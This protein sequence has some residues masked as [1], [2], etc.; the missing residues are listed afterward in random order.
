[1]YFLSRLLPSQGKDV[2]WFQTLQQRIDEKYKFFDTV[3]QNM[4][5]FNKI[6]KTFSDKLENQSKNFDNISHTLEDQYLYD[7]YK[8]IHKKIIDN[9]VAENTFA[10]ENL[11]LLEA[12]IN[13][14]KV[15]LGIYNDLKTIN[16]NLYDQKTELKNNKASYHSSGVD[17][18]KKMKELLSDKTL[19]LN[20]LPVPV[21]NQL[22]YLA[23]NPKKLLKKYK[24]SI[25]NVNDLSDKFNQKQNELFN[26]LP[27]FSN[28]DNE[29]FTVISTNFLN[30]IKKNSELL[31]ATK[32][33]MS[34][35]Q[36]NEK[37][38]DLNNLLKESNDIKLEEQKFE[39]I[40]Y[41]SGLE[42]SKCK[43]KNEFDFFTKMVEITNQ[44]MEEPIFPNYNYEIDLKN[45]YQGKLI[46]KI[47]E[48]KEIDEKSEK[49]FLDSL[50]DPMN[51][52][53]MYIV[54]SQLRTNNTFQRPKPLIELLGK[55]F[56][57]MINMAN[58]SNIYD[59]VRN[60]IILSQTY[61]YED[62]SK[63]KRYL[64]EQIKSNKILNNS[65]FWRNF[66]DSMIIGE[67][68]RFKNNHS[69]PDYNI[70]KK[71]EIPPKIIEKLDEIVF[72]QLISFI[73]NLVDFEMDKKLI[74]RIADEFIK[75]YDYL[76]DSNKD[77]IY[78]IIA[79][80]KDDIEKLRKEYDPSQESE[81]IEIKDETKVENKI[82]EEKKKEE[83]KEE[84]KE[85]IKEEKKEEKKE[86]NEKDDEEKI[87]KNEINTSE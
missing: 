62:E 23:K 30:A 22:N 38:D 25:K 13:K 65:H 33:E 59:S 18:E 8:L 46:K 70:E 78:Q 31:E 51:H 48:M 72:S 15:E 75:K 3:C 4:R 87:D 19:N 36:K 39:L 57:K 61:F 63:T 52:K 56:N 79:K 44:I 64:F 77:S 1:M 17:M 83:I 58:K 26:F 29:F 24:D 6:L 60:C 73:T 54:L 32:K 12:H 74:L 10:I 80:S 45:F 5:E 81:I 42:F 14:Y 55:A 82:K 20:D 76:I 69:L 84:K 68:E 9:I 28:D 37:K 11:K 86:E 21:K 50:D 47:F 16:K 7:T 40:Q 34:E 66:I 35:I 67:F 49:E 71:D 27:K 85:E 41:Q 53:M 43:D 2:E